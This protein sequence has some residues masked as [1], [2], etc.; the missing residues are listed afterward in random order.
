MTNTF[1]RP[2][3]LGLLLCAPVAPAFSEIAEPPL[4]IDR[5]EAQPWLEA[6][7]RA[8][9]QT[10]I[11]VGVLA[12]VIGMESGFQ[13]IKNPVSS[14]AGFGQQIDGNRVMH[15]CRLN[16]AIPEQSIMGAAL[17][18]RANLDRTGSI[19]GALR[20]YGT[21]TGMSP[22]RLARVMRRITVAGKA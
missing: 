11:P 22:A 17:E 14:A 9:V 4:W 20:S 2:A 3:L 5:P 16:R 8:A 10:G 13:N 7:M 19:A 15:I 1:S 6:M 12:E 18:L 21:T